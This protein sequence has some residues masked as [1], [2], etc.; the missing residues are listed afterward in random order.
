MEGA[1][2]L[3]NPEHPLELLSYL[4]HTHEQG[5]QPSKSSERTRQDVNSSLWDSIVQRSRWRPHVGRKAV[6]RASMPLK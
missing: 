3:L 5:K 6:L 4:L 1:M 2:E